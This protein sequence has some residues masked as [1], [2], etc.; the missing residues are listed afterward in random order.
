MSVFDPG[1]LLSR[2]VSACSEQSEDQYAN[3][4]FDSVMPQ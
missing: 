4:A 1:G 2:W 3:A